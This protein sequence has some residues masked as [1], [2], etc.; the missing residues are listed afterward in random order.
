MP[1]RRREHEYRRQTPGYPEYASAA[2]SELFPT[3]NDALAALQIP[4]LSDAA[5]VAADVKRYKEDESARNPLNYLLTAAS[6]FP[7]VPSL[8]SV[9]GAGRAATSLPGATGATG[10][11]TGSTLDVAGGLYKPAEVIA[12]PTGIIK[13]WR[14]RP[15]DEVRGMLGDLPGSE[16]PGYIS[17]GYGT[18]MQDQARR[19]ANK[20]LNLRDL[21]KAYILTRSSVN[22]KSRNVLDD[23]M[24]AENVRP[25]GYVAEWL[26]TQNGQKLLDSLMDGTVNEEAL[27]SLLHG[28]KAFGMAPTLGKDIRWAAQN[29]P[30]RADPLTSALGGSLEDWRKYTKDIHGISAAKT[31]FLASM[32]GRGD[33]ATADARELKLH[34]GQD[35]EIVQRYMKRQGAQGGHAAVDKMTRRNAELGIKV[36]KELEPFAPHAVHHAVW[37][38]ADNIQTTHEDLTRALRLGALMGGSAG[39]GWALTPT[40]ERD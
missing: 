32:L 27:D 19:L 30:E 12:R 10:E 4:V 33:R 23:V 8:A 38:K 7:F 36:P 5:G 14:W 9:R 25:E 3:P 1:D 39:L 18:F 6:V 2:L 40:E 20:D 31:P 16:L 17:E 21:M 29:L 35:P 11:T 15:M 13:D 22:R 26:L 37:D 24:Q 28:F 34:T